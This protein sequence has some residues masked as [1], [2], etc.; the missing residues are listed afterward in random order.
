MSGEDRSPDTA[1]EGAAPD[2]TPDL[3]DETPDLYGAFPR[4]TDQ[5]IAFLSGH[6]TRRSVAAGEAVIREGDRGT[7][8][9]VVLSGTIAITEQHGTPDERVLR[10]HGPGRFPGELALLQG[11]AAFFAAHVR[12]AGEVLAVPVDRLRVL[13][14]RVCR[15]S[16]PPVMC[17]AARSSG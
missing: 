5:Q 12:E 10:V 14:A 17:A 13:V 16:S 4:L 6:G 2:E 3:P 8:F 7:D 11:Q 15:G 9:L 1:P